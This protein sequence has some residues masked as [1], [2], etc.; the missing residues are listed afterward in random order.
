MGL[1]NPQKEVK[2]SFTMNVSTEFVKTM[3]ILFILSII[4]DY[5]YLGLNECQHLNEN[6]DNVSPEMTLPLLSHATVI[7]G[8]NSVKFKNPTCSFSVQKS[9]QLP[10]E[11]PLEDCNQM[12]SSKTS[13]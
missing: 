3:I 7:L 10:T 12:S 9:V 13:D 11:K 2:N 5:F 6:S 8:E 4:I 1:V